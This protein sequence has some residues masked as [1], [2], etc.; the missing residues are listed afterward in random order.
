MIKHSFLLVVSLLLCTLARGA[1]EQRWKTLYSYAKNLSAIQISGDTLYGVS[2]GKLFSYDVDDESFDSYGKIYNDSVAYI[3]Y[4]K[5]AGCLAIAYEDSNIQLL[6]PSGNVVDVMGI[7]N[8][9]MNLDKTINDLFVSGNLLYVSTGFGV[10]IIDIAK[11]AI[12]QSCILNKVVYSTCEKGGIVYVASESGILTAKSSDNLQDRNNWATF[13]LRDKYPYSNVNFSDNEVSK[14][15][16]YKD[17]VHFLVKGKLICA[18]KEDG[19]LERANDWS[20]TDMAAFDGR[21]IAYKA[22]E[23]YNFTDLYTFTNHRST[24]GDI[25][26]I[27][28][29]G[30]DAYWVGCNGNGLCKLQAE[31]QTVDATVL[32][33]GLFL[34][35]PLSNLPFSMKFENNRLLVVGGGYLW[36]GL[37]KPPQFSVYNG[38]SWGNANVNQINE[39]LSPAK[40]FSSVAV[41]PSD[42][43]HYFISGWND[44]VYEFKGLDCIKFYDNSNSTLQSIFDYRDIRVTGLT[45]DPNGNLWMLNSLVSNSIKMRSKDGVWKQYAFSEL[46]GLQYISQFFIDSYGNKWIGSST[47]QGTLFVWNDNKTFDDTSDDTY[48]YVSRFVDQDGS[49]LGIGEIKAIKEDL[50]GNIWVG[51]DVGP[52]KIY[53]S[54]TIASKSFVLNKIKIPRNDGTNYVDILLENVKINDVAIDGANQKW[55]ATESSGVYLISADGL[56]TIYHFNKDNSIL[57]SNR[58][59]SLAVDKSTG[60]AYIGT[61]KGIVSFQSSYVAGSSDY[62]NVYCYPNPVRPDY[63]GDITI[64]GLQYDSSVKITDLNG[65]IINQG[66][67]SGGTYIWDGKDVRGVRVKTGVYLV[68]GASESGDQGVA[69][70][71]MMVNY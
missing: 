52:F 50:D 5:Q 24:I 30:S 51:T 25:S 66:T 15:C 38:S 58:V 59:I 1:D 70:K 18:L 49:A 3:C 13:S 54:S 23:F 22:N 47:K 37:N 19:T 26:V 8:T 67:S 16:L 9:Q 62:S 68:F 27:A 11:G 55:F 63:Y 35:G 60:M 48:K 32:K 71:I 17:H 69:T 57:P 2:D 41:D 6:Y 29:L 61:D 39:I 10:V 34:N 7:K 21:L 28:P 64:V 56:S 40:D 53:N 36:Y 33:Q 31:S 4:A 12:L 43:S 44:G 20:P 14:I 65:N 45:F 46:K 42:T